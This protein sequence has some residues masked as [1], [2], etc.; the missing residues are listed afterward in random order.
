MVLSGRANDIL[1][2]PV[3]EIELIGVYK[4]E[5]GACRLMSLVPAYVLVE[6]PLVLHL[7]VLYLLDA[8]VVFVAES[9]GFCDT[10]VRFVKA[11]WEDVFVLVR[12]LDKVARSQT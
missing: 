11:E 9:M 4:V 3:P 12:V 2:V 5:V 6:S 7:L 10:P 8:S 1:S